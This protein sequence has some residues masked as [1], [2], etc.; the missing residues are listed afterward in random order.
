MQFAPLYYRHIEAKKRE[1]FKIE[2]GKFINALVSLSSDSLK[3]VYRWSSNI[4][5]KTRKIHYPS[6][7]VVGCN[8][9]STDWGAQIEHGDN[10]WHLV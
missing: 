1:K 4:R 6:T 8:D 3:D 7:D 10:L 2:A 9:A 5:S